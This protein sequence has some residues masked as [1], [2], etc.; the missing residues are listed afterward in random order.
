MVTDHK[1]LESVFNKPT[2]E[3]SIRVQRIVNRMLDYDFV[4]EYRSGKESTSDYTSRYP[5][6]HQTC[7]KPE[8]KTIKE[9]KQYV[10]HVRTNNTPNAVT[11]EQVQKAID[12]DPTLLALKGCI[13]QGW[14]NAKAENLQAYKHVFSELAVVDGIVVR[15]DRIVAPETLRQRMVEIAHEGHQGQ[16]RT[17]QLLR[18][19]VWFPGMDSL[20][21]KSVS[22]CVYCQSST[23]DVHREPLKMTELPEAPWRKVSVDFCGPLANGDLALVFHCQYSRYSVVEF[24]GCTS[25][26]ATIPV[27]RRVFDTYELP[28]VDKSDNSSPF[29]SHKFEE[30]AREE[31]LKHRKVTL[32][33]RKPT[34]M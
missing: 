2:H 4:V 17:K 13:H 31:G 19:H 24:V 20:R 6:P 15:G 5:M 26:E 30:Y 10:N 25:E 14:I 7:T 11:K 27:S 32:D 12:E 28:E 22:T 29:N 34:A 1:P 9:V 21:D 16:V 3:T 33:G 18:A 23:P 8:L